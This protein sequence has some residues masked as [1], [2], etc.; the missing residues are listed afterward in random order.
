MCCAFL[1]LIT[2]GPR[3]MGILWWLFQPATWSRA[4]NGAVIWPILGIAFL[5]WLTLMYVIVSP[6][7][8]VGLDWLWLGIAL[9]ADVASYGGGGYKNKDR[10]GM[11]G[12]TA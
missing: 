9:F 6:G 7:G 1:I 5:P 2:L 8:I 3:V 10:L 11:G 4:F 12:S